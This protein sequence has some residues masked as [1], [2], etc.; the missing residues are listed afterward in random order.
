MGIDG[1]TCENLIKEY[2]QLVRMVPDMR[3]GFFVQTVTDSVGKD[4]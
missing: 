1:V 3:M 4:G 2:Y